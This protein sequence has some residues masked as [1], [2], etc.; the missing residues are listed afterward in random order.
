MSAS[1]PT[2][3]S[4][5]SS[6]ATWT[7]E[8]RVLR[9]DRHFPQV[10]RRVFGR[11]RVDVEPGADLESRNARQRGRD[12]EVPVEVLEVALGHRRGVD[13]EVVGRPVERAVQAL[14]RVLEDDGEL[15]H[16]ALVPHGLERGVVLARQ[17]PGLERHPRRERLDGEE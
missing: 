1:P 11:R 3:A 4:G 13:D 9:L 12:L 7:I 14:E 16:L 6:L 5:A 15:L 8:N 17:Y 2:L 10:L